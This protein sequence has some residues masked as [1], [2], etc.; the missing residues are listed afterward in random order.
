MLKHTY[1]DAT[2]KKVAREFLM[3]YFKFKNIVGLAGPDI[4][5]YIEWCKA[6]GYDTF[7]IYEMDNKTMINQLSKLNKDVPMN[8]VLG[9][10]IQADVNKD[11]TLYDL[12][13]CRSIINHEDHVAK[14]KKNFIMT[15]SLRTKGGII[16]T[17]KHF[18]KLRKEKILNTIDISG[19][20]KQKKITTEQGDYIFISYR[21]TS[22]MCCIA[23][24]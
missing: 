21:D 7:H 5:E 13:F 20:L 15:F 10:I 4:N 3:E 14:F 2:R 6:K 18:F 17:I 1:L 12:D 19:P 9:D 23:K 16:G 11:D 24:I 22:P 8:Y